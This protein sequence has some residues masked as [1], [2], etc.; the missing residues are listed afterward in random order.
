MNRSLAILWE[1][2]TGEG[3]KARPGVGVVCKS[4]SLFR[5]EMTEIDLPAASINISS[6]PGTVRL[7]GNSLIDRRHQLMLCPH[8]AGVLT[9]RADSKVRA[10]VVRRVSVDM[11]HH[12]ALRNGQNN[13][14]KRLW[15][16]THLTCDDPASAG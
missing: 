6:P 8:I 10:P 7:A 13:A 4:G 9:G 3:A 12:F 15:L 2:Q 5:P 1:I 14:T 11:V 16:R